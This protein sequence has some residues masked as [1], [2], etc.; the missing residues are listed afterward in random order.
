MK[1]IKGFFK[2]YRFLSNFHTCNIVYQGDIF[3][4][5]EAAYQARK[6][7]NQIDYQL[8]WD[9]GICVRPN[10]AKTLGL[11]V[12]LVDDWDDIKLR[13]MKEVNLLKFAIPDLKEKLIATGDAYLEETNNWNDVYW[14]VCNGIGENNLGKILMEIRNGLLQTA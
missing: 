1:A 12:Q 5:T 10:I 4:S 14:G 3:T 13:V 8:F 11:K 9:N 6:C 7:K 2:E